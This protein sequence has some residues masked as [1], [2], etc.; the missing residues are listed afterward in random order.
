[1][2]CHWDAYINL[3]GK[4][5]SPK[6]KVAINTGI[7]KTRINVNL[8]GKSYFLRPSIQGDRLELLLEAKAVELSHAI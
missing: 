5:T 7:M 8:L 4:L 1:M 6:T 3:D 2:E